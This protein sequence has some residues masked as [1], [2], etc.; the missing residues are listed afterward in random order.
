MLIGA[1]GAVQQ[2]EITRFIAYTSIN[3]GGFMLLGLATFS[4]SGLATI[5]QHFILYL[6]TT[7]FFFFFWLNM[8]KKEKNMV[9]VSEKIKISQHPKYFKDFEIFNGPREINILMAL[10]LFSMAGLPP[11]AGFYTKLLIL[12]TIAYNN[13]L[14][15]VI[16]MAISI[17][18]TFYYI[19]VAKF[20]FVK[21]LDNKATH[22]FL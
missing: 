13:I 10:M 11:L 7:I 8:S 21:N 9:N 16:A 2:K 4:I 19:R 1:I 17:L 12:H 6:I 20:F 18:S 3:Q 15:V 14:I 5:A 22:S